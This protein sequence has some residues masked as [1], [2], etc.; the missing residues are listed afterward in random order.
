MGI[1]AQ[2]VSVPPDDG[3]CSATPRLPHAVQR[4]VSRSISSQPSGP[5]RITY[6]AIATDRI[7]EQR[8]HLIQ[9]QWMLSLRETRSR[10]GGFR[11]QSL[12]LM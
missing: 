12:T 3:C 10:S 9:H 7:C 1:G 8:V 5:H 11:R 2:P 4:A 6:G